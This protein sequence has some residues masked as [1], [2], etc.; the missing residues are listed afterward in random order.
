MQNIIKNK[1]IVTQ[2]S[3]MS[4]FVKFKFF[5]TSHDQEPYKIQKY[6]V[7]TQRFEDLTKLLPQNDVS[8]T[9]HYVDSDGDLCTIDNDR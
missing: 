8:Y 6:E 2:K 4:Y 7:E 3:D 9:I 1:K 5:E